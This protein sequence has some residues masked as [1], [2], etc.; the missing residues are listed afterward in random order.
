GAIMRLGT[1]RFQ[2]Q[3]WPL[4]PVLLPGGKHYL[5]YHTDSA[6]SGRHEFQWM[7]AGSGVVTDRWPVP[8]GQH[9]AGVSAD[10]R[11]AVIAEAKYFT[12][13]LRTKTDPKIAPVR[14]DLYDLTTRKPVKSFECQSDEVE[15]FMAAVHG[16]NVSADGKWLAT[17][18]SGHGQ[19]GRVRLW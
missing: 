7:D 18:N 5:T 15:G 2:V 10:G 16:A 11:W 8:G 4:A 17:V 6:H 1:R 13:G 19:T 12:T 3:T 9:A 14:F